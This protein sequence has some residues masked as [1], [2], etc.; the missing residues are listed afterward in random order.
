LVLHAGGAQ[1]LHILNLEL[2]AMGK[3]VADI[4]TVNTFN[5]KYLLW[6]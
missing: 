2:Q 1:K 6:K 3:P 4:S 5:W